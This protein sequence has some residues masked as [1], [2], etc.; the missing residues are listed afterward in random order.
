MGTVEKSDGG[1]AVHAKYLSG[2]VRG[3][4]RGQKGAGSRRVLRCA[5]TAKGYLLDAGVY[6]AAVAEVQLVETL[7]P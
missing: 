5:K 1:A 7:R 4:V 2:D 3:P 6:L